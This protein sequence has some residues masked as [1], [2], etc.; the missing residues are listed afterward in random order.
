MNTATSPS[1]SDTH[2]NTVKSRHTHPFGNLN[3]VGRFVAPAVTRPFA[4]VETTAFMLIVCVLCWRFDPSDPLLLK[5][6]FPWLWFATL[7]VALRYGTLLG[8]YASALLIGVW[9]V[10]THGGGDAWPTMFFTGGLLQTIIAGHFGDIWGARAQRAD[11][12]NGYLNDRLVAMTN[13]HYLMRLSHERLEKDLLSKPTTLRDSITELRRLSVAHGLEVPRTHTAGEMPG[14][15]E[16]LEFVAQACQIEVAALYPVRAGKVDTTALARL[17]DTFEID[18]HDE[19]VVRALDTKSVAHLRSDE[20]PVSQ[21]SLLVCAPLV[22][23]DGDVLALLAIRRM[24]FLSLNFDNLQLLLVLL[25]YY[26]DGVEHAQQVRDI[27]QVVPDCP[28]DFALDMSR[29]AR[30]VRSAGIASSLVALVFPHDDA[31][32]SFFEHVMR[33]R[34]SLDLL[35]PIRTDGRSVLINLMPATD[36]TG[37]DGYLARIEASLRVQFNVDLEGARIGVHTLH[38]GTG[39]PGPA[40][41]GLLTRSGI[42]G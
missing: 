5:T 18:P 6:G 38:L 20:Q 15:R 26:A 10:H 7:V 27:L 11:S 34:R 31:G 41:R 42:D 29:L 40:L 8:L 39:A 13:S 28:Y 14:A 1:D 35:W 21:T 16:L 9:L 22:A 37:V 12:L 4:I 2:A 33:R 23:A 30:L 3:A 19:L 17:G 32:D 36:E 25:G 24:P